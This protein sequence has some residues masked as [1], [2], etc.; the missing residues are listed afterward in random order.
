MLE[1]DSTSWD[2]DHPPEFGIDPGAAPLLL[3]QR[4]GRR[5]TGHGQSWGDSPGEGSQAWKARVPQRC[6]PPGPMLGDG[7]LTLPAVTLG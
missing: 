5:L 6:F 4:A 3:M 2:R 7:P 1:E